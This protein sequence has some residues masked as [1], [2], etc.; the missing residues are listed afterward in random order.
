[1]CSKSAGF[2]RDEQQKGLEPAQHKTRYIAKLQQKTP[3]SQIPNVSRTLVAS[4][5][6]IMLRMENMWLRPNLK[7]LL[8]HAGKAKKFRLQ[9]DS[10]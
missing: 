2:Q 7:S 8:I 5:T 1:M 3:R 6:Q 10:S 9:A 4:L